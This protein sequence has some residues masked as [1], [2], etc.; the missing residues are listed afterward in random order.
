MS[1]LAPF[2]AA[3][4]SVL[5][6]VPCAK[7][8]AEA[9]AD[10]HRSHVASSPA[11]VT[12]N[13]IMGVNCDMHRYYPLEEKLE[14]SATGN[15]ATISGVRSPTAVNKMESSRFISHRVMTKE[16]SVVQSH[17]VLHEK[18]NIDIFNPKFLHH[19]IS[20][21][22]RFHVPGPF[23]FDSIIWVISL[24]PTRP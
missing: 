16:F 15:L 17:R 12:C 21:Q 2:F 13:S 24:K 4:F 6:L 19:P 3:H 7:R 9:S 8:I 23:P 5:H 20:S 10:I 14:D 18:L 22:S 1:P 11:T